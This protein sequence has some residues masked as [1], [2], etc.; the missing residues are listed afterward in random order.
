ML[1]YSSQSGS[2]GNGC[3]FHGSCSPRVQISVLYVPVPPKSKHG[4]NCDM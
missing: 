2:F 3:F 4:R 1:N